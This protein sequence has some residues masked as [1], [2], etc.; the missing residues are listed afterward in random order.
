V[1]AEA[2]RLCAPEIEKFAKYDFRWT[3]GA[4]D[5]KLPNGRWSQRYDIVE[6]YGEKRIIEFQGDLIQMQNGFGAYKTM[7]YECDFDPVD[8]RIVAVRVFE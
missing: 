1:Q 8:K 2:G 5:P 6:K 4:L 7:N 3:D